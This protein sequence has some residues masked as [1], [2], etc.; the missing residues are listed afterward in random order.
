MTVCTTY[1]RV[2]SVCTD[3]NEADVTMTF[4]ARFMVRS[5]HRQPSIF[6][7]GTRVWLEGTCME[8]SDLAEVLLEFLLHRW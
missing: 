1:C 8:T 3:R 7:S 4:S 5:D 6:S 2:R